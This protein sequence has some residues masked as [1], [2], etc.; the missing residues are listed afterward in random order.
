[1]SDQ[2]PV[3]SRSRIGRGVH[4]DLFVFRSVRHLDAEVRLQRWTGCWN[5]VS[6]LAVTA[7]AL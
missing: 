3:C 4:A 7:R 6:S 1:M 5:A 2:Y